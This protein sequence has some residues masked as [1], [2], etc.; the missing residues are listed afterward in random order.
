M[1]LDDLVRI[2]VRQ[3]YRHRRR[4]W[5]VIL[6]IALGVAGFTTIITIGRDVKRNFNQDL[7]LIGSANLIRLYW[8]LRP[9]ESPDW[10]RPETVSALRHTPQVV[11]V[12][13][14][15]LRPAV[16]AAGGLRLEITVW[17]VDHSFWQLK[18]YQPAYG[19]L[20]G[21]DSVTDRRRECVLGAGLAAKLFGDRNPV[22]QTVDIDADRYQ[23]VGVIRLDDYSVSQSLFLPLS[24]ARDRLKGEVR[25]D[26]LLVRCATWDDVE[27][28]AAAIPRVVAT[29]QSAL[30][31]NVWVV[32]D[33]LRRV[34]RV[35]WWIEFFFYLAS[36]VTL[37]LGGVGIW[38]VMLAAVQ[39]R[40][41]EIGLKKAMGAEDRDILA[42]FLT[43]A[44][45]LSVG[46][47]LL[48]LA[49][50]RLLVAVAS[51]WLGQ[52][53]QEE[54]FIGCLG[55]S[56]AVAFAMGLGAGLYPSLKASRMEVVAATRYE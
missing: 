4:Y 8:D 25:P 22:G 37:L 27:D 23:V 38:N 33:A 11:A 36:G 52:R 48:G 54:L 17:A 42:Q 12:S 6:A 30:G 47:A 15:T 10:F 44:L 26:R 32:W 13:E 31:L 28:V 34:K 16:V 40:T 3:V 45:V 35:A 39:S 49:A 14:Y 7:E 19:L 20:F 5:G 18:Q 21:A 46:A 50:G 9:G 2:S 43:E 29:T 53:P 56:L 41:R 24:T 51:Y 1:R 55:L